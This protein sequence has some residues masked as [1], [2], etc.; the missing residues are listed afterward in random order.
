MLIGELI[1]A[2]GIVIL[3]FRQAPHPLAAQLG[4]Q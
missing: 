3:S 4:T 1:N 2:A